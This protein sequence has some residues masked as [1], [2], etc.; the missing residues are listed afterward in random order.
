MSSVS[1]ADSGRTAAF[2]TPAMCEGGV[3]AGEPRLVG[4]LVRS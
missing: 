4:G 1:E 2:L 3:P